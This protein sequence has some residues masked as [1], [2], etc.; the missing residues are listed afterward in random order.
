VSWNDVQ[1]FIQWINK[2][3][4]HLYRLPTEA[5]W[6]YACRAGTDTPFSFG[7]S[8]STNDANYNGNY[9]LFGCSFSCSKGTYR[10]KT[11][12]VVSFSPNAW[13]LYDMHGNVYEWCLDWYGDYPSGSATAPQ[14]LS[15][16]TGRVARGGSWGSR[17]ENSRS[18]R[19]YGIPPDLRNN[20]LGFRLASDPVK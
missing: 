19:R 14:G 7:K 17:I 3:S 8:L 11:L 15:T 4:K 5:E 6:E 12:S 1:R 10:K 9:I 18:A 2:N 13:G 20:L 16:G